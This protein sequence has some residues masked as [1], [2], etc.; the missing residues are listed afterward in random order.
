MGA[1]PSRILVT[2]ASGFVGGHLLPALGAAFPDAT[3]L[4]VG[5][6]RA[7]TAAADC[8]T[9][10]ADLSV[11]PLDDM[12][13]E[14]RPDVILHLAALSSVGLSAQTPART[15]AV[16][17][18]GSLRL[19]EA[20]ARTAPGAQFVFAGT[21]EVYGGSFKTTPYADEDTPLAPLSVYSRTKAAAEWLLGDLLAGACPLTCLRLFNHTGAG[22]EESFV[23]ASFA[24]QIARI[25][26]GKAEP[27]LRVGN[28]DAERD[29]LD[30]GDVV[31]AYVAA[32][33]SD[34]TTRGG[35]FNVASGQA[36]SIRSVLDGLLAISTVRPDVV[37]DPDR[38]RPSDIPRAS[39]DSGRFRDA[40]GWAP[41]IPFKQTLANVLDDWRIRITS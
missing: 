29:F 24:A 38:M 26:A 40:A 41:S 12:L 30:V 5:G 21:G 33:Q 23:T 1:R 18:T 32:L 31:R 11:D 28:L 25:E 8:E 35:V 17:V 36:R 14:F 27:V 22:Q 3:L 7:P 20:V 9:V 2:G 10:T 15:I 19:A 16:N 34:L 37:V 13:A 6:S 4:A 39:G